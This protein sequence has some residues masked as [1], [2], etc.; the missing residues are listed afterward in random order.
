MYTINLIKLIVKNLI[1]S[2]GGNRPDEIQQPIN[3]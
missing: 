3:R 2:D 1:K